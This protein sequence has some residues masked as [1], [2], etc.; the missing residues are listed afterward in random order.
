M[1]L[2]QVIKESQGKLFS[3]HHNGRI[4]QGLVLD[5]Q[6]YRQLMTVTSRRHLE[7]LYACC[8]Q[9]SR[10]GVG[11]VVTVKSGGVYQVWVDLRRGEDFSPI[12]PADEV[13]PI[14]APEIVIS[15]ARQ[16]LPLPLPTDREQSERSSSWQ[17]TSALEPRRPCTRLI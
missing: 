1:H 16:P 12:L 9:L 11:I 4:C 10:Q 2:P 17:T 8:C 15:P 13:E 14:E 7:V 6:I 3:F 5:R